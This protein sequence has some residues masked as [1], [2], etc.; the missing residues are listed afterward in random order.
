MNEPAPLTKSIQTGTRKVQTAFCPLGDRNCTRMARLGMCTTPECPLVAKERRM[1]ARA[2]RPKSL[3]DL[4]SDWIDF[5]MPFSESE[6]EAATSPL[7]VEC[8]SQSCMPSP[9]R[10]KRPS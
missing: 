2:G 10:A 9:H 4:H 7:Y 6:L 1:A 8:L 5:D 3:I